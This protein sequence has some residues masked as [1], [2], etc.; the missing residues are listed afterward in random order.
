MAVTLKLAD[1]PEVTVA[2]RGW[3]VI[4]GATAAAFTVTLTDVVAVVYSLESVGVNVTDCKTVPTLGVVEGDVNAKVPATDATP[5]L[6]TDD[7]SV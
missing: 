7:A 6:K 2:G 1:E 5:P 3:T 4:L